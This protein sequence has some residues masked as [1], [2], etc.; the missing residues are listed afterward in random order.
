VRQRLGEGANS[1]AFPVKAS[2]SPARP[3]HDSVGRAVASLAPAPDR[4]ARVPLLEGRPRGRPFLL[5]LLLLQG[6]CSE[7]VLVAC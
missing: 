1:T 5:L 7:Q 2:A 3:C 4:I 6:I